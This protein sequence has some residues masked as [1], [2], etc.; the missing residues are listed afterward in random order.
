M[1]FLRKLFAIYNLQA[2]ELAKGV[3]QIKPVP[4]KIQIFVKVFKEISNMP[5]GWSP[6]ST[7]P[8]MIQILHCS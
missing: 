7:L 5:D 6:M 3:R 4:L 8:R 1:I 2:G